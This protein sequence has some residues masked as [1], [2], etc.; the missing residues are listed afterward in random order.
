MAAALLSA[1]CVAFADRRRDAREIGVVMILSQPVIHVLLT[2]SGHESAS[3]VPAT[4]MVLAH[5]V[6][7]LGLTVVLA[8]AEAVLWSLAALSATVLL[9]RVRVLAALHVGETP[10]PPVNPQPV[11]RPYL[12]YVARTVPRRG[13]PAASFA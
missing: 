3:V 5:V 12:S 8:G 6:A 4:P 9:R 11:R 1:A 13:P 10:R 2:M 7:A